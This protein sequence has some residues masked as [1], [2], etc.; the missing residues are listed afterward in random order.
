MKPSTFSYEAPTT[1]E[2]VTNLLAEAA[3]DGHVL[4]GGQ[5]LIPMLRYRQ[6]LPR[7]L[8]DLRKV[9][10]LKEVA[11][12][13]GGRARLGAMVTHARFASWAAGHGQRLIV[14]AAQHIAHPAVRTMGTVTGSLAHADP[15]AEWAGVALALKGT[16]SVAG[17]DGSRLLEVK[18][19][20]SAPLRN[21]LSLGE[22]VT[23]VEMDIVDDGVGTSFVEVARRHGAPAVA[24]A[25]AVIHSDGSVIDDVR[26][27]LIGLAPTPIRAGGIERLL[28]GAAHDVDI[29]EV[30]LEVA[31]DISPV[32]DLHGSASYRKKVAPV[33]VA[34]ALREALEHSQGAPDA[35]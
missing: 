4:A 20:F 35:S 1:V 27:G 31:E 14:D 2:A 3:G 23:S 11:V 22:I 7:L 8:V 29:D 26:V 13:A 16:C 12:T 30:A 18:D 5:S 34:R 19:L 24:G 33:V 25:A 15:S 17:P 6:I 32:G 9:D 28:T 21:R 10:G